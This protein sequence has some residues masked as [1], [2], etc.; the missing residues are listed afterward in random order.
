MIP[1]LARSH[2]EMHT[3]TKHFA[4]QAVQ[5][6]E[7]YARKFNVSIAVAPI[8]EKLRIVVDAAR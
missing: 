3:G 8:D 2:D 1:K 7:A 4:V 5:A 6:N